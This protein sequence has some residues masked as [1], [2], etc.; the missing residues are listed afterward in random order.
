M[1]VEVLMLR[2]ARK[3][4]RLL[5]AERQWEAVVVSNRPTIGGDLV[6]LD[7]CTSQKSVAI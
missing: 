1:R 6:R 4:Q 5:E 2:E 3:K 7:A